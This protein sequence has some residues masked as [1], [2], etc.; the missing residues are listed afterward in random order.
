MNYGI[1]CGLRSAS[2]AILGLIFLGDARAQEHHLQKYY[3][4]TDTLVQQKLA[5]WGDMKFGLLMHWGPYSQ[6]GIVESWSIC[7]EDEGWCERRG[8]YAQNYFEYKKAY[9]GLQ[10]TFNPVKFTPEKWASA[11]RAAGMKYM[12]FTTKHHDGFAM[13]D[14]KY[15][16]YK[17]TSPNTPF[18]TNS[19]GQHRQGSI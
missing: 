3:P 17:I 9:E 12:V 2:L 16:D 14:T 19:K 7:P 4:P 18:H 1:L 8:P 15:S 13:F 6:W 5:T 10:N 11:A